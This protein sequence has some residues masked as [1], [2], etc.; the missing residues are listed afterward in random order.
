MRFAGHEAEFDDG[1]AA[2]DCKYETGITE[3]PKVCLHRE[4]NE[5][6]R[7]GACNGKERHEFR[8]RDAVMQK[9]QRDESGEQVSGEVS[10]VSVQCHGGDG[11]PPLSPHDF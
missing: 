3:R 4:R 9:A 5:K 1:E 11:A 7:D 6:I 2:D 8:K 10:F